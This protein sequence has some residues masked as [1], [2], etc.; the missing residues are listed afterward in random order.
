MNTQA[1]NSNNQKH[2]FDLV[3][4]TAVFGEAMIQF[5][6]TLPRDEVTKPLISQVVRSGTSVG[7]NYT[8]ADGAESKKDFHHCIARCKKE[9]KE[10]RHWLRMIAVAA[11]DRKGI[12]EPLRK[13]SEELTRIFSAMNRKK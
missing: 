11:P 6:K 3:E 7:A 8:E 5:V 10:T 2:P 13:E 9:A 1:Q 4:R 12:I